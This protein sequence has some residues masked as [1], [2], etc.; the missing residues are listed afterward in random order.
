MGSTVAVLLFEE[1]EVWAANVG[2]SR[3]Y[4]FDSGGL[5]Q[6]SEEHSL[7]AEQRG[8]G[9]REI[10]NQANTSFKHILTRALGAKDKVDIL[11]PLWSLRLETP[12][13]YALMVLQ[14]LLMKKLSLKF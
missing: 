4:K 7:E 3:I 9:F 2:D 11:L 13:L 12:Y 10:D 8:L 14:I 5:F 1:G 6:V